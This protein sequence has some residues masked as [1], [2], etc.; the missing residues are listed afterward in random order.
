[1]SEFEMYREAIAMAVN[2]D[3]ENVT[4]AKWDAHKDTWKIVVLDMQ[5]GGLIHFKLNGLLVRLCFKWIHKTG[6]RRWQNTSLLELIPDS[7]PPS[8]IQH[9]KGTCPG[10]KGRTEGDT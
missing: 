8:P 4:S 10:T 2:T 1:M 9:G 3:P 7:R 5:A 6:D